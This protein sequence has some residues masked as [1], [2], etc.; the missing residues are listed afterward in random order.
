MSKKNFLQPIAFVDKLPVVVVTKELAQKYQ[1]EFFQL[2]CL[3]PGVLY[4]PR[5][6]L[7]QSKQGRKYLGKWEHSLAV[8]DVHGPVG[9]IFAYEREADKGTQYKSNCLYISE[10]AIDPDYQGRMIGLGF[11]WIFQSFN[12]NVGFKYLKGKWNIR[13]QTNSN[14]QNEKVRKFYESCDFEIIGEKV[15]PNRTDVIMRYPKDPFIQWVE[16]E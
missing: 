5:D 12:K 3:I 13:L 4:S 11:M 1:T 7:R 6:V 2:M 9:L 10:M 16:K 8:F 15:Y 14:K